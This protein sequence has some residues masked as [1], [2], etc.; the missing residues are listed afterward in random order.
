MSMTNFVIIFFFILS[1]STTALADDK[2]FCESTGIETVKL[3]IDN[4]TILEMLQNREFDPCKVK[5]LPPKNKKELC[6]MKAQDFQSLLCSQEGMMGFEN[7]KGL[8]GLPTGVCWWHSQ[9]H[10]LATYQTY[11]NPEKKKLNPDVPSDKKELK[12]I[13]NDIIR[14]RGPVEIPGYTSLNDFTKDPKIKKLLQKRLQVWMAEDS[15]LKM[16]W[17]KGLTVPENYS[18]KSTKYYNKGRS[19]YMFPPMGKKYEQD[20]IKIATQENEKKEFDSEQLRQEALSIKRKS[21]KDKIKKDDQKYIERL[22]DNYMG[23]G[24]KEKIDKKVNKIISKAENSYKRKVYN[25]EENEIKAKEKSLSHQQ[26]EIETL[27]SEVNEKNKISYITVQNTGIVAHASIVFD[28]KKILDKKTGKNIYEFKVQD[29]NYQ[30]DHYS[31]N[32]GMNNKKPYSRLRYIDGK[33]YLDKNGKSNFNYQS[34]NIKVHH[35]KQLKELNKL[36]QK[37]CN[38]EIFQ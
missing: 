35:S 12:K 29:S 15:F 4:F 6:N 14:K 22:R 5:A 1:F 26:K 7:N 10:R 31:K 23:L 38:S 3:P 37:E 27:F 9:F 32:K 16:Q 13:F 19:S 11:Y 24:S 34:M 28:A 25:T 8:F 17:Y 36:F 21:I 2:A 20:M 33:W 18:K 30:K